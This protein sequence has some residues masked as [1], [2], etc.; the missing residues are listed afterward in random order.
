MTTLNVYLN[1]QAVGRLRLI[2]KRK[3]A[4][5]Y[6]EAWLNSS[7]AVP[8]S[9][10]LP[11]QPEAFEDDKARPFFANLLPEAEQRHILAAQLGVSEGNDYAI[12][13]AI[14]GECAGAVSLLPEG[15]YPELGDDHYQPLSDKALDELI[16]QLPKRP[17]LA[18]DEGIRLSLAGAQSKLPVFFDGEQISLPRGNAPSSHIIKPQISRL[19]HTVENEAFCMQLAAKVDLPVPAATVMQKD[20]SLYLVKRYDRLCQAD[21]Q[22]IRLHQ[23]DFCQALAIPPTFKYE[24]EGGPSLKAC[25]QLIRDRSITPVADARSLLNWAIFNYLIGNADAHGKNLSLMLTAN[26]PQL[27]PFYDLLCTAVYPDLTAKLAMRIGGEDRPDWVS[28]RHWEKFA[29]EVS[30]SPKLI[31]SILTKMSDQLINESHNLKVEFIQAHGDCDI[32]DKIILI[33][34]KRVRKVNNS[35][36]AANKTERTE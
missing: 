8:L 26:G 2:D 33:I 10:S 5:Q 7:N 36:A 21:N 17:M 22:T 9:L 4:F 1:A 27:A 30:I 32:I 14:G 16:K 12:L 31:I 13:E 23:E 11:L 34:E 20:Q 28:A 19:Q 18:G 25:F 24:K 35:L 6:D 15:L 29:T 3:L